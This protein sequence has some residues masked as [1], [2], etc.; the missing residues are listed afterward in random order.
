V[1]TIDAVERAPIVGAYDEFTRDDEIRPRYVIAEPF[2]RTERI[3]CGRCGSR[4]GL[5]DSR[6]RKRTGGNEKCG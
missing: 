3:A 6:L 2:A 4:F 1:I 5:D